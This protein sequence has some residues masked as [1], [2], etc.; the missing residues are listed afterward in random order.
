MKRALIGVAALVLMAGVSAAQEPDILSVIPQTSLAAVVTRNAESA[1]DHWFKMAVPL[2]AEAPE[3]GQSAVDAL[4]RKFPGAEEDQ[5]IP[6][7]ID[8]KGPMALVVVVPSLDVQGDPLAMIFKV[9]NYKAFL[10]DLAK[11]EGAA[12]PEVT[13]DGTD[14]VRGKTESTYVA[15]IG[16]FVAIAP[17]EYVIRNLKGDAEKNLAVGN[18]AAIRKLYETSDVAAYANISLTVKTFEPQINFVKTLMKKQ[19]EQQAGRQDDEKGAKARQMGQF[20]V[21]YL[22]TLMELAGE[23]EA[24]CAGVNFSDK[25]ATGRMTVQPVP[26]TSLAAIAAAVKPARADM[27][28]RFDG[29]FVMAGSW[30]M[31]PELVNELLKVL[32]DFAGRM[33]AAADEP[34]S[35]K[36]FIESYRKIADCMAGSGG[37]VWTPGEGKTFLHVTE[38]MEIQPGKDLVA[39]TREYMSRMNA[40]MSGMGGAVKTKVVVDTRIEA[41]RG[42]DIERTAITFSLADDQAEDVQMKKAL[43]ILNGMYGNPLVVYSA[44]VKDT[45]VADIGSKDTAALKAAL[46]RV[47]DGKTGNLTR[48]PAWAEA[49]AGLPAGRAVVLAM[50]IESLLQSLPKMGLEIPG[51]AALAKIK[52]DKPSAVGM[53]VSPVDKGVAFDVNVPMQEM[54]NM[55]KIIETI[56]KGEAGDVEAVPQDAPGK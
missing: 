7:S 32:D 3:K 27:A 23:T 11:R 31:R 28:E 1:A 55:K 46:D 36:Q 24:L 52:V 53:S 12:A 15:Q 4:A 13:P 21:A 38:V 50:S 49:V 16:K 47:I 19:M 2:G 5:T 33:D 44:R 6:A 8:R 10:D 14:V 40:I 48:S 17:A 20:I 34:N 25:G 35:I 42:V 45:L 51:M 41:W 26:K 54:L 56:A 18:I 43:D 9:S 29:P 39:A 37:L 22:D 30:D